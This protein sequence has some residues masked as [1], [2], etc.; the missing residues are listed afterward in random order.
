MENQNS[1][2]TKEFKNAKKYLKLIEEFETDAETMEEELEKDRQ[3]IIQ[4]VQENEII[5]DE[6]QQRNLIK[7]EE[8]LN[9]FSL[10]REAL[11]EDIK[12]TKLLIEKLSQDMMLMDAEEISGSLV[13]AFAELKKGN[14]TSMKLLMDTYSNVAETQLKIKKFIKEQEKLEDSPKQVTNVQINS[15]EGTLTDLLS[16]FKKD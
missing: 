14:V 1:Q 13:Q 15:F 16:Q 11:R 6:E 12:S 9:D 8:L 3:E 5:L 7:S 2:E 4:K 10:V